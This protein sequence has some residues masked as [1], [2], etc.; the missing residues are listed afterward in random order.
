MET[1]DKTDRDPARTYDE[2]VRRY[3]GGDFEDALKSFNCLLGKFPM[4]AAIHASRAAV[5]CAMREFNE[6]LKSYEL[7]LAIDH[8]NAELHFGRATALQSLGRLEDAL[9]SYD[10]TLQLKPSHARALNNKGIIFRDLDEIPKAIQSYDAAISVAP[11]C[12]DLYVGKALCKL[13]LG[14]FDEGFRLYEWRKHRVSPVG[15]SFSHIAPWKGEELGGK[16]LLI[17]AEQGL[18]DTIQFCRFAKNVEARGV[19]VILQ[20]QEQLVR[21]IS[22]TSPGIKVIG[23]KVPLPTCH[24]Q[25][26]LLSLPFIY[27]ITP[28]NVPYATRYLSAETPLVQRWKGKLGD[29]GFKIGISWQGEGAWE[30]RER[31]C[32]VGRSF[33]V[34]RYHNISMIPG[35]RLV[36]LQKNGGAEQLARLPS[37]MKVETLDDLDSGSDAFIDTAALMESLDLVIASDTA[38]AH[39][40]GALGRPVWLALKYM[41]DWRWLLRRQDTPWY[42]SM[43]LFRQSRPGDWGDVFMRIEAELRNIVYVTNP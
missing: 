38:V 22:T 5:L 8:R 25:A 18:G 35:V 40:A 15:R 11:T 12:A 9:A 33:E 39:L 14:E 17:Q 13:V 10:A 3:E 24:Y 29:R 20:V 2:A 30:G 42:R 16:S 19:T 6:A 4:I 32:D 28:D 27:K 31:N 34:L 7:A 26:M 21:I 36:S 23:T 43:R 1:L 37:G 41:P